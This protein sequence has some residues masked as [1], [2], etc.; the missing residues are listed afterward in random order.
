M[1]FNF[2]VP[3]PAAAAPPLSMASTSGFTFG[4]MAAAP[5]TNASGA[6]PAPEAGVQLGLTPVTATNAS[7]STRNLFGANA[8][9]PTISGL[10]GAP[11]ATAPG[12][13]SSGAATAQL[14]TSGIF[15]QY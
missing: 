11:P 14:S 10:F 13:T 12:T 1:T 15:F 2:G 4:G 5:T 9:A 6:S 8:R 3:A 7:S